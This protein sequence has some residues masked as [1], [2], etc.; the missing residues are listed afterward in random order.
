LLLLQLQLALQVQQPLLEA[1]A[2]LLLPPLQ[3]QDLYQQQEQ[4]RPSV[5]VVSLPEGS[6]PVL[7]PTLNHTHYS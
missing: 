1:V 6:L 5:L 4:Q 3:L 2:L 7:P